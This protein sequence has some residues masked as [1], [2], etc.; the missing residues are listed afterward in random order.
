MKPAA[1]WHF[2]IPPSGDSIEVWLVA[3]VSNGMQCLEMINSWGYEDGI[4]YGGE[5]A[6]R[7]TQD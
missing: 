1:Q 4:F 5:L 2:T 6:Q 3:K 7:V